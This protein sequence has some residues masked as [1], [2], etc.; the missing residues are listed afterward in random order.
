MFFPA[1]GRELRTYP[2]R[3]A[4]YGTVRYR[5]ADIDDG[6]ALLF[7]E[8]HSYTNEDTAE[9]SC[10]GGRL[11]AAKVLEAALGCGAVP[12]G[13][14][15]FTRRAFLNG[16]I[17]LTQAEAVGG[18]IDAKT[19]MHLAVSHSML[20]GGLSRTIDALT[21]TLRGVAASV[22][23]YIDYPDE[24]MTDLSV[25]EMR[26]ALNDCIKRA[27]RMLGA[28]K[29]MKAVSE[30]VSCAIVG[31]PNTGK[32]S[33][34]NALSGYERSI[35]TDIEGT[36][37]DV[38]TSQVTAGSVLLNLADTAGLRDGAEGIEK[39]GIERTREMIETSE[40]LLAVFDASSMPDEADEAVISTLADKQ[41]RTLAVLNKSD[42]GSSFASVYASRF[43]R[44][45]VVSASTGEGLD[46]LV[47]EINAMC[48]ENEFGGVDEAA[49]NAR[50][51]AALA[52]AR[53]AIADAVAALDGFTQDTAAM[54]VERAIGY[55]GEMDGRAVSEDIV[56]EIF[57]RFCVGK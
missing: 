54:D 51:N 49:L 47:E 9:I 24:D 26:G 48:G 12:A 31:K 43:T 50:Q 30:G 37:R 33:L 20:G 15:E 4:V 52:N 55:L 38:V 36:T 21:A 11:V 8:G 27:D 41:D 44:S 39:I 17:T 34:L 10:H 53:D 56:S 13:A 6:V 14:G 35:V 5:G 32:S 57:S 19:D 16:R 23:A 29:Y 28:R 40:L 22:Y 25:E 45:V 18:M 1:S 42:R 2:M 46:A 7:G 3:S